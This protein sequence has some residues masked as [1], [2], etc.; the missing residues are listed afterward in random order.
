M[1]CVT[2][3]KIR[4]RKMF[5][6]C[7]LAVFLTISLV[8]TAEA[9]TCAVGK[10]CRIYNGV[11]LHGSVCFSFVDSNGAKARTYMRREA[12][13]NSF[14]LDWNVGGRC[15]DLK[16]CRYEVFIARHKVPITWQIT[17]RRTSRGCEKL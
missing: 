9:R 14:D 3:G 17:K 1:R 7:I 6:A 15:L 8:S 2:S 4:R 12:D 5:R 13:G 11:K 10:Q 16:G